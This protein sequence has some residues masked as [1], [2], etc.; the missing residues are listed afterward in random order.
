MTTK[1]QKPIE[2]WIP[3]NVP[4]LKNSR[5]SCAKGSFYSKTVRLY[6]QSLGIR[7]FSAR[8][9]VVNYKTRPNLFM[10]AIKSTHGTL[11][12]FPAVF[13][14]HFVRSSRRKFDFHNACQIIFDLLVAHEYIPDDSMD[15]VVPMPMMINGAWYSYDKEKP[16]VIIQIWED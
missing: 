8:T 7:S 1:N 11:R 6:L 4:S 16:G 14:L 9:G 3:G 2:I 13:R 5:I 12:E 10:E 15:Y